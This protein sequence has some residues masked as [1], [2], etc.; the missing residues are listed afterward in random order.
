MFSFFGWGSD[1]KLTWNTKRFSVYWARGP[2]L[3]QEWKSRKYLSI[4][5]I[6]RFGFRGEGEGCS[7]RGQAEVWGWG[8]HGLIMA[9]RRP[10]PERAVCVRGSGEDPGR[11]TGLCCSCSEYT[12]GEGSWPV[13]V[14]GRWSRYLWDDWSA[15]TH[16]GFGITYRIP[17]LCI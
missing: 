9:E 11:W 6:Q 15:K 10:P 14:L 1:D 4:R 7:W 16:S 5:V 3:Q 2:S 8:E 17:W 13:D 12:G